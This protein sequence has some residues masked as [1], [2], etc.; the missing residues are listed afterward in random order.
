M[1]LKQKFFEALKKSEEAEPKGLTMKEVAMAIGC[2]EGHARKIRIANARKLVKVQGSR[3]RIAKLV[4]PNVIPF[5]SASKGV[6]KMKTADNMTPVQK[7]VYEGYKKYAGKDG[8]TVD[9]LDVKLGGLEKRRCNHSTT[10]LKK[11]GLVE[12]CG[13]RN[14][15]GLYRAVTN[16]VVTEKPVEPVG[17]APSVMERKGTELRKG[18][19][20]IIMP[21][22]STQEEIVAMANKL[23]ATG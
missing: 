11:L 21:P 14:K 23:A 12:H 19:V 7:K 6:K 2:S 17:A 5:K 22:G 18:E 3:Y 4:G 15:M 16:P 8:I 20:V 13:T 9:E 10:Q 1:T